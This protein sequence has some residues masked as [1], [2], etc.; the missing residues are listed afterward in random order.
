MVKLRYESDYLQQ[1]LKILLVLVIQILATVVQSFGEPC[2]FC[3]EWGIKGGRE[4]GRE[5]PGGGGGGGERRKG[6][7]LR[8][9]NLYDTA[10]PLLSTLLSQMSL[11]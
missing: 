2:P 10:I 5:G 7:L 9:H 1:V 3:S 6:Q 4:G 11:R 8:L